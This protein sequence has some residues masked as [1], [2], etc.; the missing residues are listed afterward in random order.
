LPNAQFTVSIVPKPLSGNGIDEVH[1]LFSANLGHEVAKLE[2]CASGG[3]L[4]R[5]LLALK[6]V[7]SS[8]AKCLVFDE[9]DSNVG[10]QAATVLGEKLKALAMNCQVICVTHFVQVARCAFQHFLVSKKEMNGKTFTSVSVL[11]PQERE[12]E[13]NRMLGR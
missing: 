4:S 10:G 11:A 7:I 13:Y 12:V 6:T 2:N 8:D 1:F 9:I 5:V 3:E